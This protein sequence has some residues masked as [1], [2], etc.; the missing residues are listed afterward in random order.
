MN[1]ILLVI[2]NISPVLLTLAL[3]AC[4]TK[5][6]QP[7]NRTDSLTVDS[8][9]V[10]STRNEQAEPL[11]PKAPEWFRYLPKAEGKLYARGTALSSN[12]SIAT[13]KAMFKAQKELADLV[14]NQQ[15]ETASGAKSASDRDS[16]ISEVRLNNFRVV[17]QQNVQ[18]G[19][20]WRAYVLLEL[21][22]GKTE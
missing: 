7:Q 14:E 19:N 1:K 9:T 12:R 15:N 16:E 3:I 11:P 2:K 17:K 13:E 18:E 6:E 5:K 4:G 22:Y 21:N 8:L 20:K 10:D